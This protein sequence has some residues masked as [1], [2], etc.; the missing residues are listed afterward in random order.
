MNGSPAVLEA[1]NEILTAELTTINQYF[2]HAKMCD[3]WGYERLA[4]KVRAR[5]D[6]RDEGRGGDHRPHPLPRRRAQHATAGRGQGGRD[7]ARAAR[8]GPRD[9]DR[10]HRPLQPGGRARRRRGRQR[11]AATC[12]KRSSAARRSMPT[13]S[14][15][16][17]TSSARSA[18]RT[19][20]PNRSTTDRGRP[21]RPD[22]YSP[23]SPSTDSRIR[24]AWPLWRAYSSIMWTTIQRRLGT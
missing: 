1:L 19:T 9:R 12:S 13:G 11:H 15:A 22:R 7:G 21:P 14:R 24:S 16:S 18:S 10:G 3:N 2:I 6:R 8:A 4:E 20:S 23:V 17:S 5:V